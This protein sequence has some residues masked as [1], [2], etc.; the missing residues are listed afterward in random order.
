MANG[1]DI[2][3][4]FEPYSGGTK[5]SLSNYVISNRTDLNE[6]FDPNTGVDASATGFYTLDGIGARVDLNKVFAK[7]K[8]WNDVPFYLSSVNGSN[9]TN[10][11]YN[12]V[13]AAKSIDVVSSTEIYVGGQSSWNTSRLYGRFAKYNGNNWSTIGWSVSNGGTSSSGSS[14]NVRGIKAFASNDIYLAGTFDTIRDAQSTIYTGA[15]QC[16]GG[17]YNTISGISGTYVTQMLVVSASEIYFLYYNAIRQFNKTT[18]VVNRTI[19]APAG[20]QYISMCVIGSMIYAIRSDTVGRS[21]IKI[22]SSNAITSITSGMIGTAGLWAVDI[23]NI[24]IY[25]SFTSGF[26]VNA[27]YIV[28]YNG[29]T[30]TFT[31]INGHVTSDIKYIHFENNRNIYVIWNSERTLSKYSSATN[32]WSKEI[33][34]QPTSP[35]AYIGTIQAKNGKVY[36]VFDGNNSGNFGQ[37]TGFFADY[38]IIPTNSATIRSWSLLAYYG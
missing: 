4:I 21:F 31:N 36:I 3:T 13:T 9:Y 5:A 20:T 30:N 32:T 38:K 11:L 24:Y 34:I 6:I 29:T 18:G 7:K 16:D 35:S 33:E 25:G 28:K 8:Q 10:F 2:N 26:G 12:Y 14:T 15:V 19:S 37:Y 1:Q 17:N 23:E 22:D 27:N